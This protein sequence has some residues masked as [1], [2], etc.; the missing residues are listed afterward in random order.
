MSE[1]ADSG[2]E[3]AEGFGRCADSGWRMKRPSDGNPARERASM[4]VCERDRERKSA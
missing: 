3:G 4:C 1:A 2:A